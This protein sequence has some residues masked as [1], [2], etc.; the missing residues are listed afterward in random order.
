MA[1]DT[2]VLDVTDAE[3]EQQVIERSKTTP[4]LID[5]WAPWC[6]P[7]R[8]LGPLLEKLANAYEG[9]FVLAKVNVD[10]NPYL[11]QQFN[12]SGIPACFLVIDGK[13]IS[14]FSG[15]LPEAQIREY[16]DHELPSEADRIAKRAEG[17]EEQDPIGAQRM[18]EQSLLLEPKHGPSLAALAEFAAKAGDVAKAKEHLEA[19]ERFGPGWERAERARSLVALAEGSGE[20][21]EALE[22]RSIAAPHDLRLRKELGMA[23]AAAARY[24]EALET[25][26]A[27]VEKD[28]EFGYEQARPVML[29]LFKVLGEQ[30]DLTSEFRRKLSTALY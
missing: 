8:A 1:D 30:H 29:D 16:L 23:Y 28:R 20:S 2:R 25:L 13:A 9:R 17:F 5:F 7:C 18:Y 26:L 12:V 3:F 27:I 4:V 6:G 14:Q 19:V 15:A 10:E 22:E 24:R 11:A 21:L